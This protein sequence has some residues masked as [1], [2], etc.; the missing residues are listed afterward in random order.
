MQRLTLL[1]IMALMATSCWARYEDGYRGGSKRSRYSSE[2]E[3]DESDELLEHQAPRPG[4]YDE[5]VYKYESSESDEK[6]DVVHF[7][8]RRL[9][10]YAVHAE[11]EEEEDNRIP[12]NHVE[13]HNGNEIH[14]RYLSHFNLRLYRRNPRKG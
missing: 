13:H 4:D 12:E 3:E 7:N 1:L 10:H 14:N 6:P 5:R 2:S 11:E 9:Q 8:K